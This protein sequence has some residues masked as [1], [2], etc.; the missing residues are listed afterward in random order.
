MVASLQVGHLKKE[1]DKGAKAQ[2]HKEKKGQ[3]DKD[4]TRQTNGG[5]EAI[6][7]GRDKETKGGKNKGVQ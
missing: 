3:S 2:R 6:K 5:K 7:K 4:A 1:S